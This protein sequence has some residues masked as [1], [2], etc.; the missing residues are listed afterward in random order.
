MSSIKKTNSNIKDAVINTRNIVTNN[1]KQDFNNKNK[2]EKRQ[3]WDLRTYQDPETKEL[4][5]PWTFAKTINHN[6][7]TGFPLKKDVDTLINAIEK[8]D[9]QSLDKIKQSSVT[10]RKIVNCI[11]Q[12]SFSLIGLD[13][14][15]G[16]EQIP[17]KIDSESAIFEISEIYILSLLRD[18]SFDKIEKFTN[19][20]KFLQILNRFS[21]EAITC[22]TTNGI[23]TSENFL[24]GIWHG[25]NVG[26][27]ISQ[28]LYLPYMYGNLPIQQKYKIELDYKPSTK[29]SEWLDIQNGKVNS[30]INF[31]T[32]FAMEPITKY[33]NNPRMLGSIVHNDPLYQFYYQA[34]LIC[35]Q[36]G[37]GPTGY[38]HPKN[39]DWTSGGSPFVLSCLAEVSK[40]ALLHAWYH[41]YEVNLR[42]RPEVL[43]QRIELAHTASQEL[44]EA[45]PGLSNIKNITNEKISELLKMIQKE[46]QNNTRLLKLQYPEGSP[47]HPSLPAGHAIV[48]CACT[49][50]L[51]AVLNTQLSNGSD[52][53]WPSKVVHSINGH[54]L[55]NYKGNTNN[56]TVNSEL[57]KLASNISLGRC[58]AGVHYRQDNNLLLGEQVAIRYL[59]DKAV[60]IHEND[61][62]LFTGWTLRKLDGSIIRI[63]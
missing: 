22:P 59:Q 4:Y 46:N 18:T 6:K 33:I 42:I 28:L 41:K 2:N 51:K 25:C 35:F 15:L 13:S 44:L 32:G 37:I 63:Q 49:T 52:R 30:S 47:T 1:A 24:R 34:A 50:L 20:N 54:S 56:M 39:S 36:N 45:V 12:K 26:P 17:Y 31:E 58:M 38:S 29:I 23:I 48:A 3:F 43:A 21:N 16:Y 60:S 7:K 5:Y 62:E 10:E 57:N 9:K 61:G 55:V 14:S 19:D 8:G 27:Y 11:A 53:P 40:Q